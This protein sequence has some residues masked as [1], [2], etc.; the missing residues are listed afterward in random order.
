MASPLLL[1][2]LSIIIFFLF[3]RTIL[4]PIFISPLSKVPNAH[5]IASFSPL[6]IIWKRYK[7][8]ENQAIFA[9]H[10]KHGPLVRLGP[11]ELSVNCVDE[12]LRTIYRGGFD[13]PTWYFDQ[14]KAYG[15]TSFF[16]QR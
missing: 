2:T 9:A 10:E 12:G 1:T 6:W 4:Y 11:H 3:Y 5:A 7:K 8:Q 16:C 14:F 13:K 15:Y